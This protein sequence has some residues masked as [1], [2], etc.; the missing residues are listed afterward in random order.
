MIPALARHFTEWWIELG[1]RCALMI[2]EVLALMLNQLTQLRRLPSSTSAPSSKA[3]LSFT[4]SLPMMLEHSGI[5][6]IFVRDLLSK[7]SDNF[8]LTRIFS[9]TV[10]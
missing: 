4:A 2:P 5:I 1:R 9:D 8:Y 7:V 3:T 10:L 6:R